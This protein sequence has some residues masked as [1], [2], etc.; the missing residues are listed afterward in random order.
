M[1]KSTLLALFFILP[2]LLVANPV[3]KQP[4]TSGGFPLSDIQIFIGF[5]FLIF[6]HLSVFLLITD[7]RMRRA[8]KLKRLQELELERRV[9]EELQLEISFT[10]EPEL[11]AVE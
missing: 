8:E 10:T 5:V 4:L 3:S 7:N 9:L 6:L 1:K 2:V 11:E